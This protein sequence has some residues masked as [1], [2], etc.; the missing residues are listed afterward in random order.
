[1]TRKLMPLRAVLVA[2]LFALTCLQAP[3]QSKSAVTLDLKDASVKEFFSQIERQ[4]DYTFS[5]RD[6]E[7]EA[8]PAVTVKVSK[9]GL[10]QLL[11]SEL[12]KLS[13]SYTIVGSKIVIKPVVAA[14][15]L[16][17]SVTGRVTD[18]GS[19]K[20]VRGAV[21]SD[22]YSC[23]KTDRN[24]EYV[25]DSDSARVVFVVTPSGYRLHQNS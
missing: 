22:G 20:P 10:E 9:S 1:M 7:I 2:V 5:Y 12:P 8:C 24:G 18:K 19:G 4:T 11:K 6:T 17:S 14:P 21:V 3:A 16:P 25:I 13:L 23:V 15:A